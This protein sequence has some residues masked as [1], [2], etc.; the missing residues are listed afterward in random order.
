ML[1]IT[2]IVDSCFF[3]PFNLGLIKN[4]CKISSD[5]ASVYSN[6]ISIKKDVQDV[7][8]ELQP[9]AIVMRGVIFNQVVALKPKN[10]LSFISL[11]PK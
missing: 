1:T 5:Q 2:C 7:W 11:I 4:I 10:R 3:Q 8:Q 9:I 6:T